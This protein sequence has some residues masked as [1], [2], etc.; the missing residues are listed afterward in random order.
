MKTRNLLLVALLT[1]SFVANAQQ[2][3][4]WEKWMPFVGEWSGTGNGIPGDGTGTFS[5]TFD[6]KES[7]LIRKSSYDYLIDKTY[8]LFDDM[9]II[10]LVDGIPSK[11]IFF[12]HEGF[13]RIYSISYSDNIIT[14]IT[15]KTPQTPVFKL[16]YTLVDNLTVT[17][18]YE[19]ARDGE[20][21]VTYSEEIGKKK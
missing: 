7:I 2:S 6:L 17:L 19:I 3:D 12:N 10:Y 21:F 11:A 8:I 16:T 15:E 14:L 4:K 1:V 5:F 13:S 9:M 18:K 20:S